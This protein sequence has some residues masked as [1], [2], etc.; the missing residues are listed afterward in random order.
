[1]VSD[2]SLSCVST[3]LD[4]T[5]PWSHIPRNTPPYCHTPCNLAGICSH[6]S[7][8]KDTVSTPSLLDPLSSGQICSY[9]FASNVPLLH[10]L[11]ITP[12][13]YNTPQ[14][15]G[16]RAWY[17]PGYVRYPPL[18][19][20]AHPVTVFSKVKQL[21]PGCASIRVIRTVLQL[22]AAVPAIRLFHCSSKWFAMLYTA[23]RP[24]GCFRRPLRSLTRKN[25]TK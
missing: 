3:P 12:P 13:C 8:I 20:K 4:Y 16:S 17:H 18:P 25:R 15:R 10:P 21:S 1:M 14:L 7:V 2:Q 19:T 23:L 24:A 9:S 6:S 11:G 5:H 22:V